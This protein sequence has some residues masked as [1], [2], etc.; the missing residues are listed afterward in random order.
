MN[1]EKIIAK[2]KDMTRND[3][4]SGK[5]MVYD[6][7][8]NDALKAVVMMI[9]AYAEA[10]KDTSPSRVPKCYPLCNICGKYDT[11]GV[12]IEI[13]NG[14]YNICEECADK[15]SHDETVRILKEM[16]RKGE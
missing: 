9:E 6:A 4:G 13:R 7:G 16:Y 12:G 1:S 3:A 8:Y 14:F 10:E 5:D 11:I 15:Y 2:I